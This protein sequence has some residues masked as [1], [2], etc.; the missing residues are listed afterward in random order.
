MTT[1]EA[2]ALLYDLKR[3]RSSGHEKP[4]KPVLLLA[5]MDL[6][7]RGDI[8]GNKIR[9]SQ[10]LR[11]AFTAYFQ[12]VRQGNDQ[13][14]P[15]NPYYRLAS[16]GFWNLY[17]K[18]P[19][20]APSSWVAIGRQI[21]HASILD[22]LY[23]L[24]CN[25]LQRELLREAIYSR[26][27]ADHRGALRQICNEQTQVQHEIAVAEDPIPG[28]DA[29]FRK[30]VIEVYDYRCAA[31]GLRL[32]LDNI[33]LVEAAHLIPWSDSHDD[34]PRN[35]MALCRNH[36]YAMDRHLIAPTPDLNWKVSKRLDNRRDGEA[37]LV[38]LNR[39]EILLPNL[40]QY[41]PREEALAWR[42]ERL[43]N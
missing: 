11:D 21:K 31:C 34:N 33:V 22:G 23:A 27:F 14:S 7:E 42:Q 4:H 25:P 29:A 9:P 41:Y 5:V 37:E 12:I 3:D 20:E 40:K 39:R 19:I 17:P 36:H 8:T 1:E 43:I 30:L 38:D 26:Y 6:I 24:M 28:R 16:D 35:G 18:R 2:I 10:E 15:E 32:R 13:N